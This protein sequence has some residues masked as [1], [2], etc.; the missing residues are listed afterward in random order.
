MENE[1]NIDQKTIPSFV[2]RGG[3]DKELGLALQVR[4]AEV[5]VAIADPRKLTPEGFRRLLH[6]LESAAMISPDADTNA[7][8]N[9][10]RDATT[11]LITT[12]ALVATNGDV[13][14]AEALMGHS[15]LID[16]SP[17]FIESVRRLIDRRSPTRIG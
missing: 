16:H 6:P 3:F 4:V 13:E 1:G 11:R 9:L 14:E 8:E 12:V 17:E 10:I 2:E 7:Q 15:E 5:I